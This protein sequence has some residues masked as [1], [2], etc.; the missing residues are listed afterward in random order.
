[1]LNLRVGRDFVGDAYSAWEMPVSLARR[2]V[3]Q[4]QISGDEELRIGMAHAR[5]RARTRA[6]IL[7]DDVIG[8][9]FKI[10]TAVAVE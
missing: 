2:P 5:A 9:D 8:G 3:T 4:T 10:L 7:R 1:M 6:R